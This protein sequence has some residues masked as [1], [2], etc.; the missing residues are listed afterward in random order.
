[1]FIHINILLKC[2]SNCLLIILISLLLIFISTIRLLFIKRNNFFISHQ[3]IEEKF[4]FSQR[5]K[6]LV[7]K[8]MLL[9]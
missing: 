4:T 8:I 7:F 6:S 1:M 3:Y 5:I 9:F 2:N